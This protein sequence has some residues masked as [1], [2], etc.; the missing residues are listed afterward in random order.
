MSEVLRVAVIIQVNLEATV[1]RT[2]RVIDRSLPW[3]R[4]PPAAAKHRGCGGSYRASAEL[5][6]AA[7]GIQQ[8]NQDGGHRESHKRREDVPP[9]YHLSAGCASAGLGCGFCMPHA[10]PQRRGYLDL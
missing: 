8:N 4:L 7:G 5:G 3:W 10:P 1:D 2:L 6:D 9:A